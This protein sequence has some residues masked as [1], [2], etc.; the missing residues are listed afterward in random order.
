MKVL[1]QAAA[2]LASLWCAPHALAQ[3][4][5]Q[6][7][8]QS[9]SIDASPESVWAIAG[10]FV[11]LPRWFASI[12]SAKVVL[13]K[14][15]EV[16]CIRLLTRV[17]GTQVEERLLDYNPWDRSMTYTYAGGQPLFSDYFATLT[18]VDAGNG[19]SKVEWKARMTRL[20]YTVDDAAADAKITQLLSGAYMKGLENLK[21]IVEEK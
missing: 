2:I 13:G 15:N 9:I 6:S 17:N 18:V 4:K 16:G 7:I 5:E 3:A 10:N 8:L 11:G 14:N 19:T 21:R 1:L 12:E 20:D